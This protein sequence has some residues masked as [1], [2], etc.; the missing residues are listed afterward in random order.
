MTLRVALVADPGREEDAAW[1]WLSSRAGV[2]AARFR[3]D[4]AADAL[5]DTDIVWVHATAPV[6]LP[7]PQRFASFVLQGGGLLLSLRATEL[8]AAL[9]LESSPPAEVRDAVWRHEDDECWTP[10]MRTMSAYPHVRGL[11]TYGPHPLV[12][13]L[14]N[15]TYCWAPSD[16]EPY[17]WCC[18]GAGA[19]PT[20][21]HAVAV[22]RAYIVQNA[23]RVVAWEYAPGRGRVL[24]LGAYVYFAAPDALLRPQL[25]ALAGNALH[26]VAPGGESGPRTWWPPAGRTASASEAL[27]LPEPLVLDGAL[28]EPAADPLVIAGPAGGDAPWDLAGRRQLLVGSETGG[29]RE[30]WT[31]PHRSVAAWEAL[32][33][34]RP[35]TGGEIAVTPDVVGRVLQA[36]RQ[37]VEASA[38]VALEH[39]VTVVEYRAV[40]SRRASTAREGPALELRL[41]TDLRRMWPFAAGCAGNLRFRRSADGLVALVEAESGDGLM[42]LFLSRDAALRLE[43]V[44][45]DRP[46]VRCTVTTTLGRPFRIAVLGGAD[47]D[48]L[49]R[50]LRVVRR[51]GVGGLVR[52]RAQRA[53]TVREARLAVHTPDAAFDRAVGWAKRRLDLFVGDVPGVGRSLLAGYAASTPGWGAARPGYAWFFGRDAC[54][55]AF[56]LLAVGEFSLV[57]EVL[58]FLGDRQDV[59][60]K[61]LHEATTSGQFHYDAADATPLYLLLV[62]RYLAWTG[63]AAFISSIWPAVERAYAF[64]LTTDTDGDG[65][66]ENTR[67]GHGWIESGPLA[68]AAVTLYLAAIWRAALEGLAHVADTLGNPRFQAE[69]SARAAR[70]GAAIDDRFFAP[71][72]G[73]YALDLRADGSR[74][75]KTTALV[76][77]PLLLRAV[78][79]LRAR[80]ALE[81]LAE[82]AFSAPWGV[83]MLPVGDPLFRE[84]GYH[85]GSV[86]PLFTGWASLAEYGGGRGEQGFAHLMANAALAFARQKGAFDEVLHGLLE[87]SAGVCGDQAWS[88]S[89]VVQPLV[90]GLLGVE[91]GAAWGRLTIA[92]RLPASWDGMLVEG[93]R[94]GATTF[95]LKL[96]RRR[97]QLTVGIRRTMG[98]PLWVTLAPWVPG[99]P[100]SATL[101]GQEVRPS[102]QA[103]GDGVR[104]SVSFEASGEHE[105]KVTPG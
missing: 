102:L 26:A 58:R 95:D 22:D 20:E 105:L 24:C 31:H 74:T 90:E 30:L 17:A 81:A 6:V 12:T 25:E 101:D 7:E 80:R 50:S 46:A 68:G 5:R 21:G 77:V 75:L 59:T 29:I 36:G 65:L 64:C 76:A 15:G 54:W 82:P 86:W 53:A 94:C 8:V 44:P 40:R 43:A 47:R 9:G 70:A 48:D 98:T 19:R 71:D 42:A 87:R 52:Q 16:G 78:H 73:D 66:I 91:P 79:P 92:P 63:D 99:V 97:R 72:T 14:H 1:R 41:T 32:L 104:A 35:L 3:A 96:R 83:R 61:V 13:G 38:F 27:L 51:L 55:S 56:G 37:A 89:M 18:Y 103:W 93:L 100:T 85:D 34:G 45:G 28:P 11:A 23:E 60:G 49:D 67:V 57:R 4:R 33:D 39:A 2:R 10:D 69:C 88:A 84:T 62:S